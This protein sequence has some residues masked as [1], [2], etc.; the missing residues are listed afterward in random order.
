MKIKI[1]GSGGCVSTPRPCCGCPVCKQ[2][3]EKGFPYARTGCSLFIED[4]KILIDTPEDINYALNNAGIDEVR[5]ILYSHSDPDHTMGMRVIEQ[6]KMDWLNSSVGWKNDNPIE[7][8]AL[9]VVLEDVKLQR[10]RFGSVIDYYTER[11]LITTKGI[12]CLEVND[13]TIDLL[14]VDNTE[15]VTVF[16]ISKNGKKIIYAP[17]DVKPFPYS[18]KF[19]GADVLIIG[20][21]VVGDV[22]K[23]HFILKKE[24]PIRD[25][26]FVLEEILELKAKYEIKEVIITH[27]EEDWCKMFDDYIELEKQY[28]HLKF[29][30]DGME[31]NM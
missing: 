7:V 12:R 31:I 1:I 9:P 11:G 21:T 17:C 24:N 18:E 13:L 19:Y 25:E 29:A 2:A 26:L 14:P 3:R 6:L 27:I 8:A 30:Y 22:L 16:V 4:E 5:Y 28:H 20:N 23:N 15:H 10:T